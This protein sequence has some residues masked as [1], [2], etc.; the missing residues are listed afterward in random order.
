VIAFTK[1]SFAAGGGEERICTS[2]PPGCGGGCIDDT[3]GSHAGILDLTY[4][5]CHGFS[6]GDV[7]ESPVPPCPEAEPKVCSPCDTCWYPLVCARNPPEAPCCEPVSV[8][9][10]RCDWFV[11]YL[12]ESEGSNGIGCPSGANK[13]NEEEL[14][15]IVGFSEPECCEGVHWHTGRWPDFVCKE[16]CGQAQTTITREVWCTDDMEK[17]GKMDEAL[18]AHMSK[19]ETEKKACDPTPAC[20]ECKADCPIGYFR[21]ECGGLNCGTCEK[22]TYDHTLQSATKAVTSK[23][24]QSKRKASIRMQLQSAHR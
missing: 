5:F 12:N 10:K 2:A 24:P 17:N 20:C 13:G 21:D 14:A 16:D 9:C 8:C 18:C 22:C 1:N 3:G 11:K 19:P 4:A 6:S 15:K 23:M 7:P